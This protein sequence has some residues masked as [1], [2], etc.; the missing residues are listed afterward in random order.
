MYID[1]WGPGYEDGTFKLSSVDAGKT[2][3]LTVPA[4]SLLPG[5]FYLIEAGFISASDAT[6]AI[7]GLPAAI[8]AATYGKA[9]EVVVIV[10]PEPASLALLAAGAMVLTRRRR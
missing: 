8:G 4:S 3:S 2:I 6:D 5:D 9:T 10:T 1:I 7:P